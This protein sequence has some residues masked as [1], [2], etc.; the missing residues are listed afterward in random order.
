LSQKEKVK[1]I[2][3]HVAPILVNQARLEMMRMYKPGVVELVGEGNM[4]IIMSTE[5]LK[6]IQ[7]PFIQRDFYACCKILIP[8][9][10]LVPLRDPSARNLLQEHVSGK[11]HARYGNIEKSLKEGNTLIIYWIDFWVTREGEV[12]HEDGEGL[13]RKV[14]Q[15]PEGLLQACILNL[16]ANLHV[17]YVV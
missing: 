11:I 8:L 10:P 2:R 9:K 14:L 1:Q 7:G 5:P 3:D 4:E 6:S 15:M 16:R 17:K 13:W 12:W